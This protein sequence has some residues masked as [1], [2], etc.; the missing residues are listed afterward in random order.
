MFFTFI[1]PRPRNENMVIL[2]L[3]FTG[4]TKLK[5]IYIIT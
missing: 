4:Q 2:K 1:Q 5:V 3:A